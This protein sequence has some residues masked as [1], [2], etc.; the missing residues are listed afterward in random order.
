MVTLSESQGK[1]ASFLREA[2]RTLALPAEVWAKRVEEMPAS[3]T[4]EVVI[5]RAVDRTGAMLPIAADR[6]TEGGLL[7][8][9]VGGSG[10]DTPVGWVVADEAAIPGTD[11][12]LVCLSRR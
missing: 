6:V 4:F 1:K 2:V 11:G 5:M 3:R 8:R 7:V 12:R 9:F 10:L